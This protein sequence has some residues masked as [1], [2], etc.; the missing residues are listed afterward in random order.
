M[1]AFAKLMQM[2]AA[3]GRA[4]QTSMPSMPVAVPAGTRA[5][6][7][8]Q[9]VMLLQGALQKV[10]ADRARIV[11]EANAKL[12]ALASRVRQLEQHLRTAYAPGTQKTTVPV[13]PDVPLTPMQPAAV[14]QAEAAQPM[15]DAQARVQAAEDAL[16]Y[17]N[18]DSAFYEGGEND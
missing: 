18:G 2:Q 14:Q 11:K 5:Y 12:G 3:Q 17:G 7:A 9:K 8:E 15:S 10:T 1:S 6:T 16:F 13:Q 4:R